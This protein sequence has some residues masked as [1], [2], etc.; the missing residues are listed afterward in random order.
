MQICD[1]KIIQNKNICSWV[2]LKNPDYIKYHDSEW[3]VPVF[4]D[5]KLF[6]MLILEGA[7]AGLS[8]ET[9]LKKREN[10]RKAFDNFDV[11]KIVKY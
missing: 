9:I 7:Q 2:N 4:D 10:Y 5:Q 8:W 11:E 1:E 3:G 6:E